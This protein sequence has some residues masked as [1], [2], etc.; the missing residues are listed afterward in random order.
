MRLFDFKSMVGVFCVRDINESVLWYKN[1]LGEPDLIPIEG[2]A[3]YQ[4]SDNAWLQL[5]CC[6]EDEF[7]TSSII[8]SVEDINE[9]KSKLDKIGV[10]TGDIVDCEVVLTFDF[11]DIDGNQISFAQEL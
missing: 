7:K 11:Y 6:K 2:V 10:K 1:W 4:I 3:E 5:S 9:C 8:I